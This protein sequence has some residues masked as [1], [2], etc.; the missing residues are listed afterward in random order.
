MVPVLSE[1]VEQRALLSRSPVTDV[2]S[3]TQPSIHELVLAAVNV[4]RSAGLSWEAIAEIL[5]VDLQTASGQ[6]PSL[7]WTREPGADA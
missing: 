2:D 1:R 6:Y 4:A 7:P 5:G 3:Q